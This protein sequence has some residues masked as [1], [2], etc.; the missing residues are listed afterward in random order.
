MLPATTEALV[1]MTGVVDDSALLPM[2]VEDGVTSSSLGSTE[3]DEIFSIPRWL[4]IFFLIA[5]SAADMSSINF[6][7]LVYSS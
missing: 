7:V 2:F 6:F 5:K 3:E 1:L 4:L